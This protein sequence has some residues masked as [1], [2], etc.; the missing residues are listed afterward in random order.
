MRC[1]SN[2]KQIALAIHNYHDVHG[3]YPPAVFPHQSVSVER[4]MSWFV[5]I[6]PFIEQESLFKHLQTANE[7]SE[8]PNSSLTDIKITQYLC[9]SYSE[10]TSPFSTYVGVSGIGPDA[11]ALPVTDKRGGIFGYDRKVTHSDVMDGTS[12]TLLVMETWTD[13]GPWARGGPTTVR[14][15]DPTTA[16]Y[17]GPDRPFRSEHPLEKKW[18]GSNTIVVTA[19]MADGS[20]RQFNEGVNSK[21]LEALATIAG[22]EEVK[23]DW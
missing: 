2:Q 1:I 7:W 13:A 23:W 5:M 20:A 21:L 3:R 22:G 6:L 19:S 18:F 14:G 4:R 8:E 16:P 9:P 10:Q 11:A 12:N 17:V 15:F